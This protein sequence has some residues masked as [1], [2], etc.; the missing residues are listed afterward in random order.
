MLACV[1]VVVRHDVCTVWRS[2]VESHKGS[3]VDEEGRRRVREMTDK[4]LNTLP[5][6]SGRP[7]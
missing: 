7:Q 1:V 4:R 2:D 3:D 6:P 5:G